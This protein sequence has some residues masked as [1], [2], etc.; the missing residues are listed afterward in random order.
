MS[1]WPGAYTSINGQVLK[2]F[3]TTV[4]EGAGQ[5]GT[6]V[7]ASKGELEV[8]CLSGSLFIEELQL[9]GK[10]RLDAG[11][12]LAGFPISAGTLLEQPGEAK[13]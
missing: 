6:I 7:K 1:V 9:A 13:P 5:P 11:S 4:G 10:K 8:A 3:R 12:F 2:I